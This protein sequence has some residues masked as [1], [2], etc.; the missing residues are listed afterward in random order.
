MAISDSF[1]S[2]LPSRPGA[3]VLMLLFEPAWGPAKLYVDP[4]LGNAVNARFQHHQ[5]MRCAEQ[6]LLS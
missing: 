3:F 6:R 4:P 2:G 5:P 1:M